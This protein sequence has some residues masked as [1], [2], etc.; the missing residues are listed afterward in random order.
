MNNRSIKRTNKRSIISANIRKD[1]LNVL[2][3]A[4]NP[5]STQEIGTKIGKAWHSIQGHCLRL[6]LEGKLKGF[7]VGNMNL[8]E[9]AEGQKEE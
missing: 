2:R 1:I 8:W 4:E 5:V 7:R 9:I 3:T 6:Q